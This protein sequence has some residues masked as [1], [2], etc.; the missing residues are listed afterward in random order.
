M[1]L[2]IL[3]K[4]IF[5]GKDFAGFMG[6][7]SGQSSGRVACSVYRR[8][9][10]WVCAQSCWTIIGFVHCGLML[11]FSP[12]GKCIKPIMVQYQTAGEMVKIIIAKNKMLNAV[13]FFSGCG[14]VIQKERPVFAMAP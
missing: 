12:D 14:T 6:F 2:A 1:D 5:L 8:Q 11:P 10:C 7:A 9:A 3:V 4:L 13:T